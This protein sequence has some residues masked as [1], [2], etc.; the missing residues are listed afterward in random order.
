T[1]LAEQA[2]IR[3]IGSSDAVQAVLA[4]D[5]GQSP[6]PFASVVNEDGLGLGGHITDRHVFGIGTI[7]NVE[8]LAVRVVRNTPPCPRKAGA[9]DTLRDANAS[10]AAAVN[11][12][13]KGSAWEDIRMKIA[14]GQNVDINASL[15]SRGTALEGERIPA[16]QLPPYLG[17]HG[18]RPL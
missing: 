7:W 15:A 11:S 8:K 13:M 14:T 18:N 5:R 4:H 17:G 6:R 12:S 1:H 10:V 16:A 3:K 2:L 9:F